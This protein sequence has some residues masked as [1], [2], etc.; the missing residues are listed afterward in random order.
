MSMSALEFKVTIHNEDGTLW[1]TVDQYPGAFGTGDTLDELVDSL[2]EALALVIPP[3]EL[4]AAARLSSMDPVQPE[5]ADTRML[6]L[7]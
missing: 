3:E 1:A 2:A 7:C 6:Q 4:A 5:H